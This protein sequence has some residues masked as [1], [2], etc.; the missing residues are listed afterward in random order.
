[1]PKVTEA[2]VVKI[3]KDREIASAELE[4]VLAELTDI[5]E[6]VAAASIEL[7]VAESQTKDETEKANKVWE[8]TVLRVRTLNIVKEGLIK[9]N[10][11]LNSTIAF[12]KAQLSLMQEL[13]REAMVRLSD[14]AS[15][16]PR[17]MVSGLLTA[18]TQSLVSIK[19]Q[20]DAEA[21]TVAQLRAERT[22]LEQAVTHLTVQVQD[23]A[24]KSEEKKTVEEKL[25]SARAELISLT[26][27]IKDVEK[28]DADSE[29]LKAR[30]SDEFKDL[31][32]SYQ[33]RK[34]KKHA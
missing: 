9:E 12:S 29:V 4:V 5:Q 19:K 2:Q 18:L 28:R 7:A 13:M 11:E 21:E 27:T 22:K 33:E 15:R 10:K 32:D 14:I 20:R 26:E 17:G 16:E 25:A 1:M 34:T 6:K 23:F 8:G 30:L 3:R 24:A 31:Y